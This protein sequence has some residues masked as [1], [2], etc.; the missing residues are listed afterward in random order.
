VIKTKISKAKALK[1]IKA[2]KKKEAFITEGEPAYVGR[3]KLLE[4]I[5]RELDEIEKGE[6]IFKIVKGEYGSGK[7]HLLSVIREKAFNKN[8]IVSTI[9]LSP[10]ECTLNKIEK[11]YK[12]FIKNLRAN[13][14]RKSSALNYLLRKWSKEADS[15]NYSYCRHGMKPFTCGYPICRVPKEFHVLKSDVQSAL[16]VCRDEWK[17]GNGKI[18]TNLELV[19]KWFSGAKVLLREIRTIGIENRVDRYNAI[20]YM[21]EVCKLINHLGYKGIIILLDE[22]K[23]NSTVAL[24]KSLESFKNLSIIRNRLIRIPHIYIVYTACP[25]FYELLT[26]EDSPSQAEGNA[27]TAELLDI[28]IEFM[29]ISAAK[30][31][32]ENMTF[33][34]ENFTTQEA[35]EIA[36]NFINIYETSYDWNAPEEVYSKIF[37]DFIPRA[38]ESNAIAGTIYTNLLLMLDRARQEGDESLMDVDFSQLK[39][40]MEY[41]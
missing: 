20:E 13:K 26:A 38:I 22:E 14:F 7:T 23:N 6:S 33:A 16:R 18:T 24:D 2:A 37:R 3:K 31:E 34:L 10:K 28:P 12:K 29:D 35:E 17:Y 5:D 19:I 8:F 15:K 1:I 4:E 21:G 30:K 25:D 36:Q 39:W 40:V 27:N 9:N 41:P 11:I 32:I